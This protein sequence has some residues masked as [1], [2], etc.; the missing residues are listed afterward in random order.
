[1]PLK[2]AYNEFK[3]NNISDNFKNDSMGE[4]YE[5]PYRKGRDYGD[6]NHPNNNYEGVVW[7]AMNYIN[8]RYVP[9]LNRAYRLPDGPEKRAE[10][11]EAIR[12]IEKLENRIQEANK[13]KEA[14]LSGKLNYDTVSR[15]WVPTSREQL[16]NNWQKDFTQRQKT[17]DDR[18]QHPDVVSG[19]EV[20]DDNEGKYRPSTF[21]DDEDKLGR[22]GGL[23]HNKRLGFSRYEAPPKPQPQPVATQNQP[24][25]QSQPTSQTPIKPVTKAYNEFKKAQVDKIVQDLLYDESISVVGKQRRLHKLGIDYSTAE[26]KDLLKERHIPVP[27]S[28]HLRREKRQ[29]I[30]AK[31]GKLRELQAGEGVNRFKKPHRKAA[32]AA[33]LIAPVGYDIHHLD[34]NRNNND[35]DNLGVAKRP[36]HEAFHMMQPDKEHVKQYNKGPLGDNA[37]LN[38]ILYGVKPMRSRK[39]RNKIDAVNSMN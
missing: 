30:K 9:Q 1:M 3:K 39:V 14:I 16:N 10:I 22:A 20:W 2:Q 17:Q 11:Y 25:T 12:A 13:N 26:I 5:S 18:R 37:Q 33:G 28:Q 24:T 34:A 38:E 27:K 4:R 29:E 35:I 31:G 32:A 7:E 6:H 8:S 19:K 36:N 21:M 15:K 23:V